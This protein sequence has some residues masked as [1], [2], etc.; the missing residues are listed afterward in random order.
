MSC[1]EWT[2]AI[3]FALIM[4]VTVFSVFLR[5]VNVDGTS[6]LPN[7]QEGDKVLLTSGPYTP[8]RGDVIVINHQTSADEPIIKRVIATPGQTVDIDPQNGEVLVDG[9]TLDEHRYLPDSVNT[10]LP[11]DAIQFPVQVQQGQLFVMGD[12]RPVSL[13]SRSSQIGCIDEKDVLGQAHIVFYPFSH[14]KRI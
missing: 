14:F 5:V 10:A 4:L 2:E 7:L 11:D 6:M 1:Y 12:N 8:T 3:V 9:V 13:D